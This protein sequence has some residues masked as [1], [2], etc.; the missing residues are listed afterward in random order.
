MK[1]QGF[2]TAIAALKKR[3]QTIKRVTD[4]VMQ[5]SAQ[6]VLV[7]AKSKCRF[8]EI[9]SE[10]TLQYIDGAWQVSTQTPE[11]AYV[12]FG[13]GL[14]AKRYVPSLPG[15]WQEMAWDFYINGKGRTPDYPY[16]YPAFREV[17]AHVM[18]TLAEAIENT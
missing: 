8:T 9:A 3:Q 18:D 12:E 13:T 14:F 4:Q 2:D 17:T 6:E 15:S 7:R 1:L 16:L 10:L 5:E 11:S